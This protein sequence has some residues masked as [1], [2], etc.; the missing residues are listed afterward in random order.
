MEVI[1]ASQYVALNLST[2]PTAVSWLAYVIIGGLAGWAAGN[3]PERSE[4]R[5]EWV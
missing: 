3:R 4:R 5:W 2:P 1:A